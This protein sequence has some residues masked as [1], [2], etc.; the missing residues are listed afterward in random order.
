MSVW[1]NKYSTYPLYFWLANGEHEE[2][3]CEER[4]SWNDMRNY[5]DSV[6][7]FILPIFVASVGFSLIAL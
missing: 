5:A 3:L 7:A 2:N 6:K 1:E 4:T